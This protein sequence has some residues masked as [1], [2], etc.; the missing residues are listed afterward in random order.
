MYPRLL[1]LS[2]TLML[3][4]GVATGAHAQ[5]K[6]RTPAQGEKAAVLPVL[7]N[8]SG[9]VEAYLLLEPTTTPVAGARWRVGQ[10]SL[11]AA[12]GLETGD[13]LGLVCDRKTGLSNA[14]G[15]LA[16]HCM[17]ASL[18]QD[19]S[20]RGSRQG[21]VGATLTRAAGRIGVALGTGRD[22]LPA[23][24]TP[25]ARSSKLEQNTLTVYGQ[26]HIGSEA[27]VSIGGTWA[28]AT[29]IP[30][31]QASTELADQWTTRSLTIGAGKGAFS[32]NIIG[33]V[34]E[35]PSQPGHWEGLGVGLTWRTPWSGQLT[36]GA[37]NVV[38][39]GRNPFAPRNQGDNEGTVPYV[40][41]EQDL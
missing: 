20:G 2:L 10:S 16:N 34:V 11:D 19:R 18:D 9:K 7:N 40:R 24:L 14:I 8:A 36:V 33:R 4:L 39:R 38:T 12:F 15:N 28:R 5:S 21:T 13:T 41:Y 35:T 37:E 3:A 31:G 22:S 17:L 30:V 32:A 23:W 25:N 29:L 27:T 26:K 6:A 1:P